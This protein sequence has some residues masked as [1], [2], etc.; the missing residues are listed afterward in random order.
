MEGT[1]KA[2]STLG[3]Q[4]MLPLRH[5]GL[6]LHMQSDEASDAAFVTGTGP[7]KR[8]LKGSS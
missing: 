3:R 2:C 6:A 4:I 5:R 1:D 7:A 8:N